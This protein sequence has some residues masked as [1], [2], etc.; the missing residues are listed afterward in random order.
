MLSLIKKEI[1]KM[2]TE[3]TIE[4]KESILLNFLRSEL[5]MK[6]DTR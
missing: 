2:A 3:L 4:Q 6:A 5:G 1:K